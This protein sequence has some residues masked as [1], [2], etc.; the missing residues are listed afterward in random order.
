MSRIVANSGQFLTEKLAFFDQA[1]SPQKL[2]TICSAFLDK[3]EDALWTELLRGD[4]DASIQ[5]DFCMTY[6]PHLPNSFA[7]LSASGDS[8]LTFRLRPSPK[9]FRPLKYLVPGWAVDE[10][11]GATFDMSKKPSKLYPEGYDGT[12]SSQL[13]TRFP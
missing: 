2:S 4:P 13:S 8:G 9:M 12:L 10:C 11:N 7:P 1:E 3:H 5:D 6:G